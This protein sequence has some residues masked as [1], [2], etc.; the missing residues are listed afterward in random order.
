M[1]VMPRIGHHIL[2]ST[3]SP[4]SLIPETLKAAVRQLGIHLTYLCVQTVKHVGWLFRVQQHVQHNLGH[5]TTLQ[6]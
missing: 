3:Y 5:I 2:K 1:A 6:Q 4:I